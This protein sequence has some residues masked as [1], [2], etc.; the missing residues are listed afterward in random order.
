MSNA[1]HTP[2][3]GSPPLIQIEF[4]TRVSLFVWVAIAVGFTL[5]FLSI[6]L[7]IV[8]NFWSTPS[9]V[10][11]GSGV[12]IVLAAFGGQ[13][14][15]SGRGFVYAGVFAIAL[16]LISLLEYR[17]DVYLENQKEMLKL[18][19]N[20]YAAGT[21]HNVPKE[22]VASLKFSSPVLGR[23]NFIEDKFDFIIFGKE[24][25][26]AAVASL[27]FEKDDSYVSISIPVGCI[28]SE[29]GDDR[30][31]DWVVEEVDGEFSITD[32]WNHKVIGKF[33]P[34]IDFSPCEST[35][36]AWNFV[37][38]P[39][40]KINGTLTRLLDVIFPSALAQDV[41]L[42]EPLSD[43][44][45]ST[46]VGQL[47]NETTDIRRNAR[48]ALSTVSTDQLPIL[49]DSLR[50]GIDVYRTKLG[51]VVA[52]TE[53]IRQNKEVADQISSELTD[54]DISILLDLV[55][56]PDRTVRIYATEFLYDL[57][58][59]RATQEAIRRAAETSN[60]D[61]RYAWLFVSLGGWHNLSFPEK[62]NLQ[63]YLEKSKINAGAENPKTI[64]LIDRMIL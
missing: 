40:E 45:I 55:G 14:V 25:R 10:I 58:D 12:G 61:Y 34:E 52:I 24:T 42:S 1:N 43:A 7:S 26:D 22:F 8:E 9:S 20:A 16:A 44:N 39:P 4:P 15:I 18:F 3:N 29:I 17:R 27:R 2:G 28:T 30:K 31:I 23:Q 37:T 57:G 35:A 51:I 33:P 6:G 50:N 38:S 54:L 49:L 63:E 21:I 32:R 60:V 41:E 47:T 11:L 62:E 64:D 53:N 13:A 48:D 5:I 46:L 36:S 19:A 56:D 59:P